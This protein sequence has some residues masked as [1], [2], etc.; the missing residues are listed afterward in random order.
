ME[1][2][3]EAFC[4]NRTI[5]IEDSTREYRNKNLND[6]S[7]EVNVKMGFHSHFS[8]DPAQNVANKC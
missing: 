8:D 5:S 1:I 6:V 3:S 4:F 7:N 2:Q